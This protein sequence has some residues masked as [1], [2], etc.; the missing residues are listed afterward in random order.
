MTLL[1]ATNKMNSPLTSY[2]DPIVPLGY[3]SEEIPGL[4]LEFMTCTCQPLQIL[5]LFPYLSLE[6][7]RTDGSFSPDHSE[8][9][10]MLSMSLHNSGNNRGNSS[11]SKPMRLLCLEDN[12]NDRALLEASLAEAGLEFEYIHVMSRQ[13]FETALKQQTF[14]LIISDYSLPGYDGMSALAAAK[15]FQAETPYIFVS[16]TIGEERAIESLQ[17]GATDYVLKQRSDRL[18]AAV[19]RALREK[20]ERSERKRLEEQ[21]RQAQKLEAIGQLAGGVAHDFNNILTVIQGNAQL[22]LLNSTSLDAATKEYLTQ[23][24]RASERAAKLTRQLLMFGRKNAVQLE[25]LNLE[26]VISNLSKMLI[27]VIG[28]NIDLQC[29]HSDTAIIRADVGMMEQVILNLV[30]NARDAMPRGGNITIAT[31]RVCFEDSFPAAGR[32]GEFVCLSVQDSGTGIAPEH[33]PKIFEPFFTTKEIGKGTGLGLATVF[34]IVQQHNGWVDVSTQLGVGTTFE[35]FFP[36]LDVTPTF[37]RTQDVG[38]TVRGGTETILLVEDDEAVRSLTRRTLERYG[39]RVI[40]A[41]SGKAALEVQ[42]PF[43]L[44]VTDMVM[45]E[46]I[47]GRDLADSLR[48]RVAGL[49]VIFASGYSHDTEFFHRAGNVFLQKPFHTETLL[50]TIRQLLDNVPVTA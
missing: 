42:T 38:V 44:L 19:Q 46:G 6:F 28:E 39:Y 27:R 18:A 47:T 26:E 7:L 34:G 3:G 10:L 31:R 35:C 49:K 50:R 17:N 30:V 37:Q 9:I 8:P 21:L 45:P 29:R 12:A 14:D 13:D 20:Q 36:A 11:A 23:I 4:S 1:V 16:G 25:R 15:R 40:E 33:L 5:A 24:V 48:N 2:D 43:D 32:P 22:A 41:A